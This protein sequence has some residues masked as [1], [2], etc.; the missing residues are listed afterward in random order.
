M[1]NRLI[2]AP[3]MI[4]AILAYT[5][6]IHGSEKLRNGTAGLARFAAW[7]APMGIPTWLAYASA[8]GEF[9]GGLAV[10]LG[11][12]TELAALLL[13][14]NMA[15]AIYLVHWKHGYFATNNGFEYPLVLMLLAITLLISGPGAWYLWSSC[16][17]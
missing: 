3:V 1:I 10:G 9:F 6:I 2:I 5:F 14:I 13:A 16:T 11:F 8:L 7:L 15:F 17:C 12:A 4:R